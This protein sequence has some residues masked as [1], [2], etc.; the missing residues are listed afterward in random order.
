MIPPSR[1]GV[2]EGGGGRGRET[3]RTSNSKPF[4]V[5]SPVAVAPGFIPQHNIDPY[6]TK[7]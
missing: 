4:I 1:T 2:D 5:L 3:R 6:F 7:I